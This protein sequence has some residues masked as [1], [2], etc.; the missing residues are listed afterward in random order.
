[1]IP[2]PIFSSQIANLRIGSPPYEKICDGSQIFSVEILHKKCTRVIPNNF[3][4]LLPTHGKVE[5]ISSNKLFIL[6]LLHFCPSMAPRGNGFTRQEI[7]ILLDI[8]EEI[9]PVGGD[10][11]ATVER[12]YNE[13][14]PTDR[15]RTIESL[16]RKYQSLYLSKKPTGDPHCPPEVIRSKRIL[17]LQRRKMEASSGEDDKSSDDGSFGFETQSDDN[18]NNNQPVVVGDG[19]NNQPAVIN[20]PAVGGGGGDTP[21][22]F[23]VP[24]VRVRSGRKK[25]RPDDDDGEDLKELFRQSIISQQQMMQ[26]QTIMQQQQNQNQQQMLQSQNNMMMMMMTAVCAPQLQNNPAFAAQFMGAMSGNIAG[27]IGTINSS[28]NNNQGNAVPAVDV[29]APPAPNTNDGTDS[30]AT[31][32]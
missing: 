4:F 24:I 30:E 18:G 26:S 2:R 23:S 7:Q 21:T 9:I 11:W 32:V 13:S 6:L 19:H 14:L 3:S 17:D 31:Q 5:C 20:Q 25:K 29:A 15:E 22:T 27:G 1:M 12:R 28:R 10:E 16:R 8:L